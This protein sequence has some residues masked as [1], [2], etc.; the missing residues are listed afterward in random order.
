MIGSRTILVWLKVNL[1]ICFALCK[2]AS[3]WLY[4]F[5]L[6]AMYFSP[7]TIQICRASAAIISIAK[8]IVRAAVVADLAFHWRRT[9][10]HDWIEC[11]IHKLY[12]RIGLKW[13]YR[14]LPR[15]SQ[16]NII[17]DCI[18]VLPYIGKKKFP[19]HWQERVKTRIACLSI[20]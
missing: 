19:R 5:H 1:F 11:I 16:I 14:C 17:K 9:S 2:S 10:P 6:D 20:E 7:F 3:F 13:I 4:I 18:Y 12:E 8:G 15:F